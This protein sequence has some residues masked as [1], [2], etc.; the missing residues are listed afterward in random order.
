MSAT[1]EFHQTEAE[2]R[3]RALAMSHLSVEVGHLYLEDLL[4]GPERLREQF[5]EVGRWLQTARASVPAPKPRISTCFLIDDYFSPDLGDPGEVITMITS[6]AT[7]AGVPIDYLAR[8]SACALV[9]GPTGP[10]S[11]AQQLVDALVVEPPPHTTGGRPPVT[12][13]G[14]LSNGRRSPGADDGSAMSVVTWEPPEQTTARGHS[15][16]VDVELWKDEPGG[17]R[18]SCALLAAAWQWLRL[19]LPRYQ[20]QPLAEPEPVPDHWPARWGDLPGVLRLDDRAAPFTAQRTLSI[21]SSRF[22]LVE[23]AVRTVLD[24]VW[25]DPEAARL[26]ADGAAREGLTLPADALARVGYVLVGP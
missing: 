5:T 1:G 19:G 8:E 15:V 26:I 7:E 17:R 16:F 25:Q 21:M 9:R 3:T 18:W 11:P 24:Q 23:A 2:P 22:L 13:S 14:W 20:G 12:Q 6:A 4:A 10:V